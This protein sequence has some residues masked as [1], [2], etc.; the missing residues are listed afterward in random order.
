MLRQALEEKVSRGPNEAWEGDLHVLKLTT[1]VGTSRVIVGPGT[2]GPGTVI[3]S[4]GSTIVIVSP[5]SVITDVTP[6]TAR[7]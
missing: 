3:T 5:S 7:Y 2:A 4:P 6:G 1:V